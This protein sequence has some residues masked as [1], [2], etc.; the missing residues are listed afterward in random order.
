MQIPKFWCNVN[1][2]IVS[3][4][5]GDGET[6]R[7]SGNQAGVSF[8]ESYQKSVFVLYICCISKFLKNFWKRSSNKWYKVNIL[9]WILMCNTGGWA[10]RSQ[11]LI[12]INWENHK[13]DWWSRHSLYYSHYREHEWWQIGKTGPHLLQSKGPYKESQIKVAWIQ[14]T[15]TY[16][17]PEAISHQCVCAEGKSQEAVTRQELDPQERQ[18]GSHI[19]LPGQYTFFLASGQLASLLAWVVEGP[20][21]ALTL[22]CVIKYS[23]AA[24]IP[25]LTVT[26]CT[27]PFKKLFHCCSNVYVFKVQMLMIG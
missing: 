17:W 26:M 11:L 7:E 16:M 10:W 18:G 6:I 14:V 5:V 27:F 12:Q 21:P 4:E 13:E 15:Q 8:P 25:Q 20:C 3:G 1:S 24:E 2:N 23:V 19:S 9:Y 22:H